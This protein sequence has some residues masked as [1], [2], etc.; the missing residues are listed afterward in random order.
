MGGVDEPEGGEDRMKET[1][2]HKE[3]FEYYYSL[4]PTRSIPQVARQYSVSVAAVKK[5]S[6]AFNWQERIEQRDIENARRAAKRVTPTPAKAVF[7]EKY[8]LGR[9][10]K[11]KMR[12]DEIRFVEEFYPWDKWDNETVNAYRLAVGNLPPI[13]V[14]SNKLLI[15]G[16]HRII[17]HQLEGLE[18]IDAELVDVPDEQ[19]FIEAVRANATH[20]KQLSPSEK[21]NVARKLFEDG[22]APEE[23]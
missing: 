10:V 13:L 2:R 20:G 17:A 18:E 16:Y 21:K 1:L 22:M 23:I 14:N 4:G 11:M 12:I 6:R 9:M 15:D 8:H 7:G 19:V 5:W 3:A